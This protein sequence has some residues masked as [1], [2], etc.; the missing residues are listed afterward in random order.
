VVYH[1]LRYAGDSSNLVPR[2]S[3]LIH[4]FAEGHYDDDRTLL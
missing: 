3:M 4:T 2:D 1:R